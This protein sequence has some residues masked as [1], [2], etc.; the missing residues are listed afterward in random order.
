MV[1]IIEGFHCT[2]GK[3]WEILSHT[4]HTLVNS[5]PQYTPR[6]SQNITV[7][8]SISQYTTVYHSV[9]QYTTLHHSVLHYITVRHSISQYVTVYHSPLE[10]PHFKRILFPV[11]GFF[12]P[13][14]RDDDILP[15][16][17]TA[18]ASSEENITEWGRGRRGRRRGP[19]PI[20]ICACVR[21]GRSTH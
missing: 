18:T 6:R 1:S 8:Y 15:P 11:T 4:M 7:Y 17:S 9:L 13:E 3:T 21:R 19:D 20:S 14:Y 16:C 12:V 5:I 10:H 2:E